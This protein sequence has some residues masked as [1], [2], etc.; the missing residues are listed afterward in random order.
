MRL[1]DTLSSDVLALTFTSNFMV[2]SIPMVL[3]RAQRLL[4]SYMKMKQSTQIM[5]VRYK[6]YY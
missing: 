3:F 1:I 4:A 2:R 6:K 5:L